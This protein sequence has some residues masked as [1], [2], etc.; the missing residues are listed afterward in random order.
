M[1]Y[2][3]FP[4]NKQMKVIR[5]SLF[6]I[7]A[8]FIIWTILFFNTSSDTAP[9]NASITP[10]TPGELSNVCRMELSYSIGEIDPRF[11]LSES[12]VRKSMDAAIDLWA[13]A[14][15]ALSI[16]YSPHGGIIVNFVYDERQKLTEREKRLMAEIESLGSSIDQLQREYDR[17]YERMEQLSSQHRQLVDR[18]NLIVGGLNEWVG[19]RNESGGL[20]Q[21]DLEYYESQSRY[22]DTLQQQERTMRNDLHTLAEIFNPVAERLNRNS[23]EMNRLI[24][25][26]NRNYAGNF[27]FSSGKYEGRVGQGVITIYHHVNERHL[28]LLLAHELGHAL[29]IGHVSNPRSIMYSTID[30]QLHPGRIQLTEEDKEALRNQCR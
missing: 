27:S 19:N 14:G 2:V 15:E 11:R 4:I 6:I 22:I 16:R 18:I 17:Y 5:L 26:Y 23:D 7:F 13:G 1:K 29:G 9:D 12:A 3:T 24:D 21:A 10:I 8:A 30:Q 25:E 28:L 20:T